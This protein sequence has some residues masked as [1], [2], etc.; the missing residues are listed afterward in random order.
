M[1][2]AEQE[3][4]QWTKETNLYLAEGEHALRKQRR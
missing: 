1:M 4:R 3:Y 2:K